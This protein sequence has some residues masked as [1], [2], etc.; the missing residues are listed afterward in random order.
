MTAQANRIMEEAGYLD[1]VE[2]P[3]SD[4]L[5]RL[6]LSDSPPSPQERLEDVL[7]EDLARFLVTALADGQGRPG[8]S[9]P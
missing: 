1:D 2:V 4:R 9:S 5:T 6:L 3:R 8:S 7:G